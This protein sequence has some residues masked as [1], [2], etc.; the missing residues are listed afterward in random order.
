MI[1]AHFHAHATTLHM[2][3]LFTRVCVCTAL[4]FRTNSYMNFNSVS[5][6]K[7]NTQQQTLTLAH[8]CKHSKSHT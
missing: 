6:N 4:E 3:L 1:S 2:Y 8:K 7:Q 5:N